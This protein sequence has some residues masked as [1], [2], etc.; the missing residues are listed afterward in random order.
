MVRMLPPVVLAILPAAVF[1]AAGLA[2]FLARSG[3]DH[4]PTPG[5]MAE[6]TLSTPDGDAVGTVRFQQTATGVLVIA[7][8]E[9]L[10]PGGHAFN[11]HEVGACSPD[12]AAAGDHFNPTGAGHG[13]FH[14]AWRR[15]E[16]AGAHSGDLPN[17]YA[18]ADGSA[19]ADFFTAGITLDVGPNHSIFDADGSAIIV[20]ERPDSYGASEPDTGDRLACGVINPT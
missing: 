8:V 3:G 7:E 5:L 20:H 11:I 9:G 14:S 4:E 17:I 2:L 10:P 16:A 15:G 13:F 1:I 19:R 12:F 6:A 18:A